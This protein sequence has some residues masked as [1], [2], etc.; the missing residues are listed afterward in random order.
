MRQEQQPAARPFHQL[1]CRRRLMKPGV[2]QHDH[3]ARRQQRQ[4]H[5]FK[6][7]VHHL[8]VATALKDQRCDQFAVLGSGDDARALPS[9]ACHCLIN[10]L[11][12]GS[13]SIFTI[14]AV[15]HAALVQVKDGLA[16]KLFEFAPEEP[17][18]DLVVLAIFDEFFLT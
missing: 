9:F 13:A 18:L 3:A 11:P 16:I 7:N 5:L 6:I 12:S 14:Q 4:Q 10:P 17:P 8:G 1:V 2:V 15:I